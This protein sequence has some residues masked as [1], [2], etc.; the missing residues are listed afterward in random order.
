MYEADRHK[1]PHEI[2]IIYILLLQISPKSFL[3]NIGFSLAH[4]TFLFVIQ[5]LVNEMID[6]R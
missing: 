6:K 5:I 3:F 2:I 4:K 1:F